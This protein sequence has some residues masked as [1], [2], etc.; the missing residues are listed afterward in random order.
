MPEKLEITQWFFALCA[1]GIAVCG[2]YD[3]DAQTAAL[4]AIVFAIIA[5]TCAVSK[6][7]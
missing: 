1:I 6:R 2:A 4:Y 5:L 7:S 3:K